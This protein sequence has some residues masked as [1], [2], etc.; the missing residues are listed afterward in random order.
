MTSEG[1]ETIVS[2]AFEKIHSS[3]ALDCDVRNSFFWIGERHA[4][5]S[6]LQRSES[7]DVKHVPHAQFYFLNVWPLYR[8]EYTLERTCR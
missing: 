8:D 3:D 7:V 2:A 4:R 5:H 6:L 1:S